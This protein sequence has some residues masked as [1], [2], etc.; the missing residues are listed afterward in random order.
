[1]K[2]KLF[3]GFGGLSY[4]VISQTISNFFMFFATSVLGVSGTL[5]GITI[6][7]STVWDGVSDTLVGYLSDNYPM[8]KFGR[9][10]GYMLIA[11]FG[12]SIFNVL[13]WSVPTDVSRGVKFVWILISLLLVET[14]NTMFA[15]P[16]SALGNEIAQNYNDRTKVNA[17]NIVFYLIGIIIPSALMFLFLPNTE[18]FPIGQ[19]NP[20]GYK[21]IALVTSAISILFGLI[22]SLSTID[23]ANNMC[24]AKREKFSISSLFSNFIF[25]FKNKRLSRIIWG[26]VFTSIATVFLCSVG[27]HFFTYSLFYS[28][29]QI[30]VL[31]FSLI[32]GTILSQPLWVFVSQKKEKKPA[33]IIGIILT[34]L[35][36]F[37]VILVYLFRI[38]LFEISFVLM[39]LLLF[40][41]G[42][43]SGAMYGLPTS[44]FGDVV[45]QVVGKKDNKNATY[46]GTMTFASNM[47]NSITQLVVGVLLDVI[48]FDS[49]LQV[50]SLGVQ[51]GL[52]LILFVGVQ[53]ALISACS[54][55]ASYKERNVPKNIE[56]DCT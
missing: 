19:L 1:M 31:L 5:V 42:V 7:I 45:E 41:C 33:L 11:T 39:V 6:G 9:R 2:K 10:N 36:I 52:A 23:S 38:E 8:G 13:L 37:G 18:E 24:N 4:S 27:M 48:H 16:Y 20:N 30:T 15:T 25:S 50:Q 17:F 49:E 55:F 43:G 34:I 22:C 46:G 12:M 54:I 3:Y 14:F 28:S 47:A 56:S 40:V 35:S 29:Q 32:L 53:V 26:Y 51:T 44:M 21:R